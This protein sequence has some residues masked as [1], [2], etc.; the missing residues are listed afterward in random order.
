MLAPSHPIKLYAPIG[1]GIGAEK[2]KKRG[3]R[4]INWLRRIWYLYNLI[5]GAGIRI[6]KPLKHASCYQSQSGEH[7]VVDHVKHDCEQRHV[8]LPYQSDKRW[9]SLFSVA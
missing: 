8:L 1:S 4:F 9:D 7:G 5:W 3:M 6:G 2:E